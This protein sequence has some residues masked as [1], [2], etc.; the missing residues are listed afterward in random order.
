MSDAEII[1]HWRKGARDAMDMA[2]L[3]YEAGK[4]DHALFNCQLAVE[5]ALKVLHMEKRGSDAPRTHNLV[6]LGDLLGMECSE[7]DVNLLKELSDFAVDAR[8]HDPAWSRE[9]ATR[10]N[11]LRWIEETESFLHSHLP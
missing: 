5:K 11:A 7:R 6:Y 3:A 10:E 2:R 8:Y 4:Y 1:A 9:E